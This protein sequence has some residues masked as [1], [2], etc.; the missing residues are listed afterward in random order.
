MYGAGAEYALHSLLTLAAQAG[1]V[2]VGD[3]AAFQ[4]LP[5]TY[6]AKLFTRLQ[7]ARLV[8]ATEGSSGGFVLAR[9]A[10]TIRVLEVLEA[11][12][13]GRTLFTCAEIRRHCALFDPAPPDWATAGA[14]RIHQ[15]M[16]EA[17]RA[18]QSF[19][20]S[21]TLADLLCEFECKAPKAF[22]AD[23]ATWFSQR[24]GRGAGRPP[25]NPVRG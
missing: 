7:K 22:V 6:L 1:P 9:P 13:P 25:R 4:Q 2:S 24:K 11:V 14:C 8:A 16:G 19:L 17:E 20:A 12:D 15:F 21:R 23:A 18:L 5:V 3:L 10:A